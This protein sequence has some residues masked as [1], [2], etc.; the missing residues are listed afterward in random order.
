MFEIPRG[1]ADRFVDALRRTE[2][3]DRS[4]ES[5]IRIIPANGPPPRAGAGPRGPGGKPTRPMLVRAT[6]AGGP[7]PYPRSPRPGP[8]N[9]QQRGK[10]R[11]G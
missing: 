8:A 3:E 5:G 1:L 4:P 10:F 2:G 11:Q 9:P 6:P 7:K